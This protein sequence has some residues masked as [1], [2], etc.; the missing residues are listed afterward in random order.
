MKTINYLLAILTLSLVLA[1]TA[2]SSLTSAERAERDAKIAQAVEKA[3]A[4]RQYTVNIQMMFP[5]RGKAVNVSSNY[6]LQVKGDTLVSYLPFFGRAYS[7][8]YG[9]GDG[10]NFTAPIKEYHVQKAHNGNTSIEIHVD[11]RE[12][13]IKY[14]LDIS[15]NGNAYVDVTSR[16]REPVSYSG[17][18]DI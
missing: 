1:F 9:G 10:Y 15:P 16:E 12:N 5:Q 13:Y 3:L 11:T 2:C 17:Q 8:P 14:S 6:S 7:V 4:E 18:V